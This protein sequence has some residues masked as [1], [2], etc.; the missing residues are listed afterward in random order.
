MPD[1]HA[2]FAIS[3]VA[4]APSPA[5]TG[6]S[7][8]VAAGHGPRFPSP[9]FNVSVWPQ[10]QN[11]DPTNAEILRVTAVTG[12]TLTIVRGQEGSTARTIVVGDQIAATITAKTIT[13]VEA[14][15]AQALLGYP[16]FVQTTAPT[17]GQT[18]G[19][20]KWLWINTS[21]TPPVLNVEAGSDVAT[22]TLAITTTD[23]VELL[24]VMGI[25]G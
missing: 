8:L 14:L 19:L 4:T 13:D 17:G 24:T 20:T 12:A 23:D 6:T 16:V 18:T 2:N 9:P 5:T 22:S 21:S 1:A 10:G 15:A 11:P 7:L 3:N 25:L